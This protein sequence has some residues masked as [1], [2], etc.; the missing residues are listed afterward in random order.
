M[1]VRTMSSAQVGAAS[2][3]DG[4][5]RVVETARTIDEGHVADY[6]PELSHADPD[7]VGMSLVSVLGHR[8]DAG[9]AEARFT[10]QSISKP[11][12]Y[13]LVHA[14]LGREAL[15]RRV[16]FEPSGEPFNAISLDDAGR[17]ANPMINAGAI[18]VSALVDGATPASRFD[19]VL[20]GLSRFAGRALSVDEAVHASEADTG[21][22]NRALASLMR[23]TGLLPREVDDA[24]D[25][26]FRQCAVEVTAGDL[27][28]MGATLANDGVN[29]ITGERVTDPESAQDTLS[30]MGS[31]GMYDRSGEWGVTVGFPAKSGVGGGIVAVKPGQFGVGTFAPPLDAA[32]NSA[33]GVAMLRRLSEEYGGHLLAHPSAP[34]SPIAD[35]VEDA[36]TDAVL[37]RLRGELDFVAVEQVLHE[38]DRIEATASG[39][40][41]LTVD[42]TDVTRITGVARQLLGEAVDR[43]R[44]SARQI[45]TI[46]PDR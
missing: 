18:M 28:V 32:G 44:G 31:C 21:H 6:I 37:L 40:A 33:R 38:I 29:P 22:R 14:R 15:H 30:L 2:V 43:T 26:Y 7:L 35:V 24:T 34:A 1:T 45:L 39:V 11:F 27:A 36:G 19:V 8:Y 20:D 23:S 42:L 12:V 5:G 3:R 4:L 13:A 10:I 16:G 9:D 41:V 46:G 17:P 25:V